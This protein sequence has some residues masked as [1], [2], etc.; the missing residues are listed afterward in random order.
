MK[1]FD[2]QYEYIRGSRLYGLETEKSDTDISGWYIM[3]QNYFLGI[4]SSDYEFCLK[5]KNNISCYDIGK[6]GKMLVLSNPNVVES[7]F[8]PKD[9]MLIPPSKFIQSIFE[10]KEMFLTKKL[11]HILMQYSTSQ[12]M[13]ARGLNKKIVNP[14][15]DEEKDVLDFCYT[16]REQGSIPI[17]KWLQEIGIEQK[18]CGL[19]NI[20]HM[21][22]I[23]G[24][25]YNPE[26]LY[27]G[28]VNED[29]SSKEVRLSS[30]DKNEMP[31]CYMTF[32]QT[33][34]SKYCVDY[35][36]YKEWKENRNP[37]RYKINIDSNRNYDVKNISHCIRLL[38]MGEE[39]V[40]GK[41]FILDRRNI[42]RDF[43]LSVKM[44]EWNYDDIM[45]I[46]MEKRKY[47]EE[48]AENCNLPE[49][50]DEQ[51]VND[52]IVEIRKKYFKSENMKEEKDKFDD[53]MEGFW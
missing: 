2:L 11:I 22:D 14:M 6:V 35:K 42:D 18:K 28:I 40:N 19:V 24:L 13:K 23:Y 48:N 52:M 10:N 36:S 5:E 20:P 47:I 27:R 41:G 7:L 46:C 37:E 12:I 38:T 3:P 39:L 45:K 51:T 30:V 43:I 16:F 21:H 50:V 15:E 32:N 53:Y 29:G 1:E 31:L 34:Y 44:G 26:K 17:K 8:V 9:K 25:Y 49:K 4:N 33:G